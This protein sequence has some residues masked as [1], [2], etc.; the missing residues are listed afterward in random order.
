MVLTTTASNGNA[1]SSAFGVVVRAAD[2]TDDDDG[3]GFSEG[4][5][6]TLSVA[7]SELS[8]AP[9]SSSCGDTT[10]TADAGVA[11]DTSY[12]LGLNVQNNRLTV[13]L[14]G[15]WMMDYAMESKCDK[16]AIALSTS[17]AD[18]YFYDVWVWNA[19]FDYDPYFY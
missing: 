16:G 10:T 14:D 4:Y 3:W 8:I 9:V 15:T 12:H 19:T 7:S 18:G 13:Y 5:T 1:S 6:V 11:Y 17:G 2:A